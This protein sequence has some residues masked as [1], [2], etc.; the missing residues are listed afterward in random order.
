MEGDEKIKNLR[1]GQKDCGKLQ[2]TYFYAKPRITVQFDLDL[3][4][5]F[6]FTI[7][8]KKLVYYN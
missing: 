8:E 5:I 1:R 3:R 7:L 2:T 4:Q 6:F